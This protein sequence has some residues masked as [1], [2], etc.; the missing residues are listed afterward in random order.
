MSLSLVV[1]R[2]KPLMRDLDAKEIYRD[3]CDVV[4]EK[5]ETLP[6]GSA[7]RKEFIEERRK[8]VEKI[9]SVSEFIL[10]II[11]HR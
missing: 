3:K 6:E 5:F 11:N 4:F 1:I 9:E 8:L 10:S 2:T 7:E